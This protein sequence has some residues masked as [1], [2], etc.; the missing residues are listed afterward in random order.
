MPMFNAELVVVV[1]LPGRCRRRPDQARHGTR[2]LARQ[3]EI[4]TR[5]ARTHFSD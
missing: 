1:C 5:R 3:R 2:G 4:A